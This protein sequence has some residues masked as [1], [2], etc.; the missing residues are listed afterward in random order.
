MAMGCLVCFAQIGVVLGIYLKTK[1]ENL[2]S[3]ALPA[4]LSGIFG[5]TEPAI[6]GVTLPRIK[7]FILSCLGASITGLIVMMS[8]T[9]MYSFTGMGAFALLG[10][11]NSEHTS[12]F[13]PILAVVIPFAVSFAAS[14]VLYKDEAPATANNAPAPAASADEPAKLTGRV[15]ISAPIP[16]KV[17]SLESVPDE[18]FSTGVLGNGFAVEPSEG[19]VYAPFDGECENLADTLHAMGLLSDSGVSVLIHVGLETVGL[20]G[21]PFRP[22]VKTGDRIKKG[23]LLLEFDMAA[24]KAAGCP[25]IVPVLVMNEDEVGD[26]VIENDTIVIGG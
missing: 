6:Y 17:V 10:M 18:T 9:V 2:K 15:E 21:K 25:T 3:I 24:I 20:E 22:H 12:L 7:F 19:K 13:F 5:V 14:F 23:Q 4:F 8:G 1:D 16:G 11:I 26:V